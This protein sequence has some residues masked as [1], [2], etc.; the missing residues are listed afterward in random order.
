[1]EHPLKENESSNFIVFNTDDNIEIARGKQIALTLC[2]DNYTS[3]GGDV[4]GYYCVSPKQMLELVGANSA[5]DVEYHITK[6][7]TPCGLCY[8]FGCIG[9]EQPTFLMN[10]IIISWKTL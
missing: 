7:D 1:M 4:I 8:E 5:I 2:N 6:C 9:L 10:K 3:G